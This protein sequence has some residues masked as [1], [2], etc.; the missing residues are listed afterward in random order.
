MKKERERAE[1][2]K[3][4][5]SLDTAGTAL[6]NLLGEKTEEQKEQEQKVCTI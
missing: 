6:G 4:Q 2:I 5:K 3:G 1:A